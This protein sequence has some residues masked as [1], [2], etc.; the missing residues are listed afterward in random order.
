MN[1]CYANI[2]YNKCYNS[3]KKKLF[4]IYFHLPNKTNT[5]RNNFTLNKFLQIA[6][7]RYCSS[8]K[9]P[10][11]EDKTNTRN[12]GTTNQNTKDHE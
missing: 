4:L 8:T 5:S 7:I 12:T 11:R 3:I 2:L 6:I 9:H 1:Y 10:K